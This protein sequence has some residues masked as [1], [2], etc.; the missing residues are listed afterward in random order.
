MKKSLLFL[1]LFLSF[2][3]LNAQNAPIKNFEAQAAPAFLQSAQLEDAE[4]L[5]A[6][7]NSID[8][9]APKGLSVTYT[10]NC[11]AKLKWYAPSEI[12]WDNGASGNSG[13]PST[14]FMYE[15]NSRIIM[16]DDFIVPAGEV[17]NV[18]EVYYGGF[19]KTSITTYEPPDYIGIGIYADGGN[20]LP[21]STAPPIYE[22]EYLT[23]IS[24]N[25]TANWQTVV[26]P[27]V[28][29][30][31]EGKYWVSVYGTYE[32]YRDM[33][34]YNYFIICHDTNH[35][36]PWAILDETDDPEWQNVST[37]NF[38]NM[39]FRIRGSF[40]QDEIK[41][42]VYRNNV[43][44]AENLSE[45]TYIDTD[46]DPTIK[47][48]WSVR[49]VCSDGGVTPPINSTLPPCDEHVVCAKVTGAKAVIKKCKTATITW[50][51]VEGA[52]E[53]NVLREETLLAT[54][55]KP[56]YVEENS[57]EHGKSYS[58][59]IVT[60]CDESQSY[61]LIVSTKA[62]CV[63]EKVTG[64]KA[65]IDNCERAII[66]WRSIEE[67]E[68]YKISRNG[69]LL[70]TVPGNAYIEEGVFE[71]GEEYVWEIVTV[72]EDSQSEPLNVIAIAECS[73]INDIGLSK[74][75]I[76][77]NPATNSI[78]ITADVYF[79]KIE[80]INLLGKT[81]ISQSVIANSAELDVST[82]NNGIYF[83]RIAS[84]NGSNV[85]KFLKQ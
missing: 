38:A 51:A 39:A 4:P 18:Y 24:G 13:Y 79:T 62:G 49:V 77:P 20:N 47:H 11:E 61:P 64:A 70:A 65:V 57:F 42:N 34:V 31:S 28:I 81:I 82:L 80:V 22:N 53:Y 36:D 84:E 35:G 15:T 52:I 45:L 21:S 63:C 23:T 14:R 66:T 27:E 25:L 71:H 3:L 78:V 59:V 16:A 73:G 48:T 17:W 7:S 76:V 6:A 44:I 1:G 56:I 43:M 5:D 29:T 2:V 41:Y 85:M 10:S 26:L 37:A 8:C 72:C 40:T 33:D 74:F 69:T 50:P 54:V 83:V 19:Y 46:F 30:L 60:I 58:W 9:I 55:T 32:E 67:A 68:A 12:L 75:T